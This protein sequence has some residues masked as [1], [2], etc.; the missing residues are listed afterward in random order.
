M[1]TPDFLQHC[2]HVTLLGSERLMNLDIYLDIVLNGKFTLIPLASTIMDHFIFI[3]FI[4][5]WFVLIKKIPKRE[6][7]GKV[8][9]G[10]DWLF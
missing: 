2:K 3:C 6:S 1:K 9:S 10:W 8:F 5:L 7:N 4:S